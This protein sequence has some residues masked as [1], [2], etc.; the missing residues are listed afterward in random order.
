MLY[1]A[2]YYKL[3]ILFFILKLKATER[4]QL[5]KGMASDATWGPWP[6]AAVLRGLKF[7]SAALHIINYYQHFVFD[8]LLSF[9]YFYFIV[10][11]LVLFFLARAKKTNPQNGILL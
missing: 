10:H 6:M 1:M 11:H 5:P 2:I 4:G 3:F 8:I 9:H 7:L